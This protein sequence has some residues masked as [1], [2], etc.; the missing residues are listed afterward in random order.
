MLKFFEISLRKPPD[1]FL[2][3]EPSS[4]FFSSRRPPCKNQVLHGGLAT[5]AKQ[6]PSLAA[7]SQNRFALSEA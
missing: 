3:T 7:L 5:I 4:S 2:V 6:I 1:V